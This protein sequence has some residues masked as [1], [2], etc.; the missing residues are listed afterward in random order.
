MPKKPFTREQ[1]DAQRSRIMDVASSVMADVGFNHL[2]MRK[3]ASQLNM[4]ASN[5]YNYFPNKKV[6]LDQTRLRG[7]EQLLSAVNSADSID[8]LVEE[9]LNFS[10]EQQGYYQ[11][12]FFPPKVTLDEV[13]E[14]DEDGLAIRKHLDQLH[15][16]VGVLLGNMDNAAIHQSLSVILGLIDVQQNNVLSSLESVSADQLQSLIFQQIKPLQLSAPVAA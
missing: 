15:Q 2:S 12:M 14:I 8:Q 13:T 16:R 1:V 6:L 3:L 7:F 10:N 4:T 9:I 11:L 5:I